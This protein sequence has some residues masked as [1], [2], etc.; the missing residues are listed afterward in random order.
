MKKAKNKQR[1]PRGWNQKRVR[2]VVSHYEKQTEDEQFADIE[3]ARKAAGITMI[4][5]PTELV[6]EIHALVAKRRSA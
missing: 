5:V 1:Y 4:G 3:R 2:E 6:P